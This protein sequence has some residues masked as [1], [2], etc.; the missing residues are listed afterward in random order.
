ME[1]KSRR[2][3]PGFQRLQS[4]VDRM[5]LELVRSERM[6]FYGTPVFRP[7]ADVYFD[8]RRRA[9]VVKLELPGIDPA[10]VSLEIEDNVLRVTGVRS[11]E[12][13]ADA[14]YYQ[15]EITYGRFERSVALPSEVDPSQASAEYRSGYLEIVIPLRPRRAARRIPITPEEQTCGREPASGTEQASGREQ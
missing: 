3:I 1:S 9:V 6:T 4:E 7:N 8:D 14:V 5:F 11:D 13:P 10:Q 2:D 15:M 12:R